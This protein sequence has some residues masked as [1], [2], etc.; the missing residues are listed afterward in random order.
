[1]TA[2]TVASPANS[3]YFGNRLSNVALTPFTLSH[4]WLT[5]ETDEANDIVGFGYLPGGVTVVGMLNASADLDSGTALRQTIKIGSTTVI[6]TDAGA[7]TGGGFAHWITPLVLTAPAEVTVT[8]TTGATGHQ[9]GTQYLT[10]L[11]YS[12]Q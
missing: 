1:M 10:F 4:A 3:I 11:Y 9:N 6:G 5:A 12:A 7:S 8:T 2:A